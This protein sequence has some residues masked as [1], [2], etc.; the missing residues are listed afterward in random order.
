MSCGILSR[1]I[2]PGVINTAI[3]IA[4]LQVGS[5]ILTEAILSFLGA[6]IP[7][8]TPAWGSMVSEGRLY[9]GSAWWIAIFP[10][11]AIFLTVFAFNFLGDWLRDRFDPRLRQ[12]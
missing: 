6:G 11:I 10:G 1:H 12:L 5:L 7:P 2:F 8:P 3:V 4:T 9:L